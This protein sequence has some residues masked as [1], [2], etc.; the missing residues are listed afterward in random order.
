MVLFLRSQFCLDIQF[1]YGYT[2]SQIVCF[3]FR[4]KLVGNYMKIPT[5]KTLRYLGCNLLLEIIKALNITSL[6]ILIFLLDVDYL[7]HVVKM[8]I[9]MG[10][11]LASFCAE[12]PRTFSYISYLDVGGNC[13][14][15]NFMCQRN[16]SILTASRPNPKCLNYLL[17]YLFI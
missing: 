4:F 5:K 3:T 7:T 15:G 2:C 11:Y 13:S 8:Q 6:L 10:M 17:F 16:S 12:L 1:L 9:G 14:H